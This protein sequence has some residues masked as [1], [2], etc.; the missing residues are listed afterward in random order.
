MIEEEE[1]EDDFHLIVDD[2]DLDVLELF[3]LKNAGP[4][5]HRRRSDGPPKQI[6]QRDHAVGDAR[7]RADYFGPNPVYS[8]FQFRRRCVSQNRPIYKNTSTMAIRKRSHCHT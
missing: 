1:D 2:D 6:R 4:S 7:I 8:A 5:H 3:E